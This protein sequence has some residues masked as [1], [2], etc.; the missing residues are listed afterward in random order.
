MLAQQGLVISESDVK[1]PLF[2]VILFSICLVGCFGEKAITHPKVNPAAAAEQA[3]S[4]YDSDGDGKISK[5]EAKKTALDPEKGWDA[6][7]DGSIDQA[8]IENRL[9]TYEAMKPGLQMNISCRVLHKRKPLEGA[10]V[11]YEPEAFLGGSTPKA[12]G[13]SNAEG[14][15]G[16]VSEE[17]SDATLQG[18]YTGLYLVRITHPTVEIPAKYNTETELFVELSPMDMQNDTPTFSIK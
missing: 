9:T 5:E 7:G 16:L 15:V 18:V 8:E 2:L 11:V 17:L 10:E 4:L 6:N 1:L 3:I 12:S 14:V 13:T